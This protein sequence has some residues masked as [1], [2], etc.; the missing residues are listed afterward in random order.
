MYFYLVTFIYY[1][2]LTFLGHDLYTVEA[3]DDLQR[4]FDFYAK[5]VKNG[6]EKD[7]PRI[8]LT[9]LG[10]ENSPA[11]TIV[12][13]PET[14]WPPARLR[15]EKYFLDAATKSIVALN[16]QNVATVSHEGHSLTASSVR[17][18]LSYNGIPD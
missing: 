2:V 8:R 15:I 5:G 17:F 11:K 9:L 4:F 16:P 3:N 14:Q 10:Y 18:S 13:R 6:W 7:T 1:P 12:E